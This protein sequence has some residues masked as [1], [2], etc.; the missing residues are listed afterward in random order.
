MAPW[1]QPTL[2][3]GRLRCGGSN[4]TDGVA[5]DCAS[6][7]TKGETVTTDTWADTGTEATR[8]ALRAASPTEKYE[9][10]GDESCGAELWSER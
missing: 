4:M 5:A 1:G 3:C 6:A 10:G 9:P 7:G 8:L 2:C